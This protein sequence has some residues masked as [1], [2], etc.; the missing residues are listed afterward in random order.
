MAILCT[1]PCPGRLGSSSLHG[2][3][4]P[5]GREVG[6][7][8]P[9]LSL[10]LNTR[11]RSPNPATGS[12]AALYPLPQPTVSLLPPGRPATRRLYAVL[13]QAQDLGPSAQSAWDAAST[14]LRGA[15]V[16]PPAL[17]GAAGAQQAG[18]RQG[19]RRQARHP[20]EARAAGIR[21][22]A[23]RRGGAARQECPA[24]AQVASCPP[25]ARGPDPGAR[26]GGPGPASF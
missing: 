26:E 25:P 9:A 22:M 21:P 7:R 17:P 1:S 6:E 8:V 3:C 18:M 2:G 15:P 11:A 10:P 16:P 4:P 24:R 5:P 23:L 20:E 14:R 19:G 12:A 13:A